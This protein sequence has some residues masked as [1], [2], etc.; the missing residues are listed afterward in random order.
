MKH[1]WMTIK[2]LALV[3]LL[4]NGVLA[5]IYLAGGEPARMP[6]VAEPEPAAMKLLR[7]Q[8]VAPLPEP[9]PQPPLAQ[10]EQVPPA[11]AGEGSSVTHGVEGHGAAAPHA[12]QHLVEG[13][14]ET[15]EVSPAAQASADHAG[16]AVHQENA[17]Q[18]APAVLADTRC[19]RVGP[20][21]SEDAM[22]KLQQELGE[23]QLNAVI[24]SEDPGVVLGHW[25]YLP[26][27][28]SL[29]L[30]RLKLEELKTKGLKDVAIVL[31]GEPKYAISLGVF[32]NK[33]TARKRLKRIRAMGY[34]PEMALRYRR[35]PE[36]WLL[37]EVDEQNEPTEDGWRE[38]LR[39]FEGVSHQSHDC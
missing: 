12:E 4:L 17:A 31:E 2:A 39:D 20:L 9:V 32:R 18:Q 19:F 36:I 22:E 30:A 14:P 37:V 24:L 28:R 11:Q 38:L 27:Q 3:L 29:A 10:A 6:A 16:E 26:P 34:E 7:L 15:A 33:L 35:K 23:A 8:E 1:R 13:E 21:R 25:V 5:G